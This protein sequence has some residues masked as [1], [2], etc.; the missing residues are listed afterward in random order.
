MIDDATLPEARSLPYENGVASEVRRA[1]RT[2]WPVLIAVVPMAL[3]LG[4]QA[5]QRGLSVAEVT[6]M[7]ALNFAGGSEF[8]AIGVWASPLPVALIVGMTLL[9]NSRHLLMGAAIAPYVQHLPRRQ[10]YPAL[11]LMVDESWALSL[12]DARQRNDAGV[13]P[14]FSLPFY[15]TLGLM[16][17]LPWSGF[18]TLGAVLGP[19]VG[20]LGRWGLDMVFPAVFLVLV[21]GMWTTARAARP[22]LASLVVAAITHVLVP[23]AWYVPAGA[24]AGLAA[25]WFWAEEQT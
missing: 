20:D 9:V 3:V 14:S 13:A 2:A 10:V 1:A 17:W 8:A 23:G 5:T 7:T 25:A 11:F 24:V 12:A 22:W 21:R 19:V 16:L 18:A 6:L 15:T 4:A